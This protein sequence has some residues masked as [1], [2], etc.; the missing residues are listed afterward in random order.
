M[1]DSRPIP[2]WSHALRVVLVLA[3]LAI[4]PLYETAHAM[5]PMAEMSVTMPDMTAQSA[6]TQTIAD[7]RTASHQAH[8][9]ACRILCFGWVVSLVPV[10]PEGLTTKLALVLTPTV[11][12]L[13]ESISPAPS[14]HP[15]KL[16]RFV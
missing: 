11:I 16:V 10:R 5:R 9:A 15:P 12:A 6:G 2:I 14:D 3:L 1:K 8:D 7:G 4:A 13:L